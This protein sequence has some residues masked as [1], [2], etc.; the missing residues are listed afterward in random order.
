MGFIKDIKEIK[1]TLN[2]VTKDLFYKAKKYD[3]IMEYLKHIKI[4]VK[5]ADI[6]VSED[7]QYNVRVKYEIPDIIVKVNNK[8]DSNNDLFKSINM[9]NLIS[10]SDMDKI[11]KKIKEAKEKNGE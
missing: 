6:V 9:L 8:V 3:E 2:D 5:R 1:N 10:V 11:S 4:N 7:Y